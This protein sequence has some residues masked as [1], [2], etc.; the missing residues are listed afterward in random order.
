MDGGWPGVV[1][2]LVAWASFAVAAAS[3]AFDGARVGAV[4]AFGVTVAGPTWWTVLVQR[5][6]WGSGGKAARS[7]TGRRTIRRVARNLIRSGSTPAAVAAVQIRVAR[8]QWVRR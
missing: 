6:F 1:D 2:A 7:V 3:G 8:A 5:S 4:A